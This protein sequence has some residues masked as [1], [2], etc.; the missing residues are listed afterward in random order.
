MRVFIYTCVCTH[1]DIYE[2]ELEKGMFG[3][4]MGLVFIR[5]GEENT[6]DEYGQST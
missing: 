4:M 5:K 1:T 2:R 3:G 6:E